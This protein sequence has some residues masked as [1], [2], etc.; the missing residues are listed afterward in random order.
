MGAY[1]ALTQKVGPQ[2]NKSKIKS[3]IPNP[4]LPGLVQVDELHRWAQLDECQFTGEYE[5]KN[6]NEY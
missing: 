2:W 4:E 6:V 5:A 3:V 1:L